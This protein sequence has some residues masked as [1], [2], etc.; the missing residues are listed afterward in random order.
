MKITVK[1]PLTVIFSLVTVACFFIF[2][3]GDT[4]PRMFILHGDFEFTN[5]WWYASLLGYTMGHVTVSHLIGN[6]S[7]FILLGHI[8]E[9][10]YGS[11][12]MFYMLTITG[13]VTA[14]LHIILFNHRLIGASGLVFMLIVLSSL[15]D[16]KDKE[17]PLTFILIV[18][19]FIGKEIYGS[20][21]SDSIS[22]LAHISGG[23][24]GGVFG[25]VF[26]RRS[27]YR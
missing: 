9:K 2:Q 4:I 15:V 6:I 24:L 8:V 23:V 3:N 21:Q 18:L 5:P 14:L 25:Y 1:A 17:I 7:L 19:L 16:L 22:Q 26:K 11:V 12:R 10:R 13:A 27:Q 20:F